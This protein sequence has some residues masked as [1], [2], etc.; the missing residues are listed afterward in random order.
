MSASKLIDKQIA[1]LPDWRGKT[2]AK[3]RKIIHEADPEIVEEWKWNTAVFHF[4]S[5]TISGSASWM[6]LRSLAIVLPRQSGSSAICLSISLEALIMDC[7]FSDPFEFDGDFALIFLC[8]R[9]FEG[10]HP[11]SLVRL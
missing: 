2:I 3:L 9:A 1:E 10:T 6:I 7:Y 5:S 8:P 4:H 11:P